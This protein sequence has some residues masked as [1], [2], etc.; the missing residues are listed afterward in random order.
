V[1]SRGHDITDMTEYDVAAMCRR[2]TDSQGFEGSGFSWGDQIVAE[3]AAGRVSA[4]AIDDD[5]EDDSDRERHHLFWRAV[6]TS[7]HL[8]LVSTQLAE[9]SQGG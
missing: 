8:K 9:A 6:G 3:R 4:N 2:V 1:V 5:W 7:H